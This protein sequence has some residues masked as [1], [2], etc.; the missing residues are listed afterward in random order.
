LGFTA[1]NP[2]RGW[3][4]WDFGKWIVLAALA[5]TWYRDDSHNKGDSMAIG[6]GLELILPW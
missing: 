3:R 6:H 2:Y 4:R 1:V 5:A